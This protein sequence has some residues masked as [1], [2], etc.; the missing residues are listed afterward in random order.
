V[1][2]RAQSFSLGALVCV[3]VASM[4]GAQSA[5]P[6]PVSLS[7]KA[8]YEFLKGVN[9]R[10]G[11]LPHQKGQFQYLKQRNCSGV[12]WPDGVRIAVES[13]GDDYGM[14]LL[15][16][17]FKKT[18]DAV[19]LLFAEGEFAVGE[20]RYQ[21][22]GYFVMARPDALFLFSDSQ[23]LT[24]TKESALV[25]SLDEKLFLF[26]KGKKRPTVVLAAEPSQAVL[27]IGGNRLAITR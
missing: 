6:P 13:A 18:G 23:Y 1:K 14:A 25:T 21:S 26:G 20:T 12:Q 7:T 22:G 17:S 19:G 27:A 5:S 4:V 24:D 10:L 9:E 15:D 16:K 8:A 11:L 3:A 2:K